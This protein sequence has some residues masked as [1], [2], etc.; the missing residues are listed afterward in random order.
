MLPES[1]RRYPGGC[2]TGIPARPRLEATLMRRDAAFTIATRLCGGTPHLP[3]QRAYAARRRIY[4]R[5]ALMR[6]DAAFTIL[7]HKAHSGIGVGVRYRSAAFQG[8][9]GGRWCSDDDQARARFSLRSDV[10]GAAQALT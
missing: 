2:I 1:L 9:A 4:Y 6:R 10:D 5:N 8:G 3:S 7:T